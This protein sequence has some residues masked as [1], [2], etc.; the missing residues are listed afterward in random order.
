MRLVPVDPENESHVKLLY[1]LLLARPD[2]ANISHRETP[3][4]ERHVRFVKT[5][6]YK[7]WYLIDPSEDVIDANCAFYELAGTIYLTHLREIGIF[8][9]PQFQTKHVGRDAVVMLM[10][11]QPGGDFFANIAP[12]NTRS[13]EFFTRMGFKLIQYTYRKG[14]SD[15]T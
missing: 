11:T 2:Y 1:E 9:F 4:F 3:T 13:Q 10:S 7:S 5:H 6:S 15:V 12:T 8:L 14:D